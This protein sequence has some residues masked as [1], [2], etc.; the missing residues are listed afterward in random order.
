VAS[1][2][3]QGTSVIAAAVVLVYVSMA[4][5]TELR[6]F[7]VW[8]ASL[9]WLALAAFVCGV[10]L[11]LVG[12]GGAWRIVVSSVL[13]VLLFA[14]LWNYI[15]WSF[16]GEYASF[17]ELGM[18]NPY[19]YLVLPRCALILLTTAPLGLLGVVTATILLPDEY[20]Q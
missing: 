3:R 17:F 7:A 9:A 13:A 15:F 14:G 5:L 2:I 6:N 11:A 10:L 20:R 12:E 4:G 1:R 18:S 16:L 8:P 19:L